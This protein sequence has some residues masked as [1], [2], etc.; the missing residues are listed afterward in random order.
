MS[1]FQRLMIAYT[2]RD[3]PPGSF[4]NAYCVF[5]ARKLAFPAKNARRSVRAHFQC[6]REMSE[7]GTPSGLALA[8]P[9]GLPDSEKQNRTEEREER[10]E[11]TEDF[12]PPMKSVE[13]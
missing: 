8:R 4:Q 10:I 1:V 2:G 6:V 7:E 11:M 13:P 3:A 9:D 12:F 5:L